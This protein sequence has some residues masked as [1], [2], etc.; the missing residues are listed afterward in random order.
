MS[1]S[2]RGRRTYS[3]RRLAVVAT[4]GG[5]VVGIAVIVALLWTASLLRQSTATVERDTYNRTVASELQL[6]L[7]SYQRLSNQ[8]V[9]TREPGLELSTARLAQE[10]GQNLATARD[11]AESGRERRLVDDAAT[12]ITAYITQRKLLESLGLTEIL[13]QT[14]PALTNAV[15]A[16]AKLR[17]FNVAEL[18]ATKER[19]REVAI[20]AGT[21]AVLAG[22]VLVAGSLILVFGVRMYVLRPL[23]RVHEVMRRLR[24][25][26]VGARAGRHRLREIADLA[27][28]L[29]DMADTLERQREH[30][31]AFLAGVAHDLRNP[32]FGLKL[33]ISTL[34]ED[35]SP[36]KRR[37]TCARLERQVDRL[38]R[39]VGDLLDATRIEA[40][41]LE[42]HREIV[43]LGDVIDDMV[44]LYG[45]TSPDHSIEFA[46]PDQPIWVAG[47]VLRLEQ[48]VSNLLSNAI[49]FSPRGGRI[50]IAVAAQSSDAVEVSVTDEGVG[51]AKD[52]LAD[53][54]TPFRRARPDVAAG[55]GLGLSVV[56]RI[57][58]AH[59]GSIDVISEVGQG[60]TFRVRLPAAVTRPVEPPV[61]EV[62][63]R[64]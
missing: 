18:D 55:A 23:F 64:A 63:A 34:G 42:I 60:S 20:L 29:N 30:Q 2:D 35:V 45:P 7:L 39:M 50:E 58:A 48:V 57:I 41:A 25:G 28:G 1:G 12:N 36:S 49:K 33:G 56:R 4:C 46:R 5:V 54:F 9:V 61:T 26:E 47:D 6:A 10:M 13:S 15:D 21:V 59:G 38:T 52:E 14:Q 16:A 22:L 43:D 53:I 8:Y 62:G 51:I 44:R 37:V 19:A 3:I 17:Q 27:E 32:L 24:S 11:L 31:L 40:G